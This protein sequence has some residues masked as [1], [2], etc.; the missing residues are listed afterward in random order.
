M[1]RVTNCGEGYSNAAP[2][3]GGARSHVR[4]HATST[5][6]I[7]K[8]A[9]CGERRLIRDIASPHPPT[10]VATARRQAAGVPTQRRQRR[11]ARKRNDESVFVYE[12]A[13]VGFSCRVS[14]E[15]LREC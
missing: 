8:V 4:R 2:A 12:I 14:Y 6:K 5:G 15:E 9:A 1:Q 3:N 7:V 11:P 13:R 10:Y